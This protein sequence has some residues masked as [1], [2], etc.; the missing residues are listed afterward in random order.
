MSDNCLS[1]ELP[2]SFGLMV[3]TIIFFPISYVQGSFVCCWW[4]SHGRDVVIVS[5]KPIEYEIPQLFWPNIASCILFPYC[6]SYGHSYASAWV[7]AWKG[8]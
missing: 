2:Y 5:D 1:M 4:D 8:A 6:L 3:P 7:E